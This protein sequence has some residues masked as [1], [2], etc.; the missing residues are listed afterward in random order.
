MHQCLN[1]PYNNKNQSFDVEILIFTFNL[2]D[3]IDYMD[4]QRFEDNLT[5][6]IYD[7]VHGFIALTSS[8]KELLNTSYFQRLNFIKQ[9]SL[10]YFVF[11]GAVH[12][13]FAHSLGVL[14]ITEKIIQRLKRKGCAF[15][16][17]H[18]NHQ[19]TRLAALLHDIGHYPLSHTIE[20]S[21]MEYFYASQQ[22]NIKDG[23]NTET[24][25]ATNLISL[26]HLC[27][28]QNIHEFLAHFEKAKISEF[29][30]EDFAGCILKS[31]PFKKIFKALFKDLD[32][33]DIE[34]IASLITGRPINEKYYIASDIINSKLDADQMDYMKRDTVNTGILASVDI[35]FIIHNM[36]TCHIKTDNGTDA[37]RLAFKEDALQV[38]EQFILAKYYWYSNI[39]YFDKTYIM[40]S[41]AQRLYTK[42]LFENKIDE[43]YT[44]ISKFNKLLENEPE[45]FFFFNDDYFW[46][47]VK[48]ILNTV[49]KD[50]I[51][52]KL[53]SALIQRKFPEVKKQ[54]FLNKHFGEK[55]YI[56]MHCQIISKKD[57]DSNKETFINKIKTLNNSAEGTSCLYGT[58][59]TR[60]IATSGINII[61]SDKKCKDIVEMPNHFFQQ[62]MAF[63]KAEKN[64]LKQNENIKGLK[65]F[66]VYDFQNILG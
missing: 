45:K 31:A 15:F 30:H 52:Y 65:I 47:K 48:E 33:N 50:N 25:N 62:F 16:N 36:T 38:I 59:I 28:S 27:K 32:D 34:I 12:T 3:K 49:Q 58:P 46:K 21:Y 22:N 9:L 61:T 35:D 2:Y 11:P 51:T 63:E 20:S 17:D 54:D 4:K 55:S 23:L 40:N 24:S 56:N 53:A 42:C 41:I 5:E 64:T 8:E 13:R 26:E 19:I 37:E 14:H 1:M 10:S 66:R 18:K 60:D 6:K 44:S 29:N 7:N 57:Y 43:E 39:L